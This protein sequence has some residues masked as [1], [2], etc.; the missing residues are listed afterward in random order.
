M[1]GIAGAGGFAAQIADLV[2]REGPSCQPRVQLV[3]V[4]EPDPTTH[5]LRLAE[6]R[7]RGVATTPDIDQLLARP[8]IEAVW[9]PVPIALH[10]PFTER[11]LAAGKA[12][13]VEKPA[14]GTVQ[15]V[16]A[17]IAARDRAQLPVAVGFQ[18]VYD[19]LTLTLKRRLLEGQIG[20]VQHAVLHA[21]WPRSEQYFR[22]NT[23]AGR[24][25]HHGDW[26]LDSPAQ[27]AL[28]HVVN[29]A[30]FLLGPSVSESAWPVRVEAELYR[31]HAIENYDT[32]SLRAHLP[33]G[34]TLLVL[35]THV[36]Q[37]ERGPVLQL[38]GARGCVTWTYRQVDMEAGGATERLARPAADGRNV[39]ERFA[40]LVRGIPDETRLV[41]TLE[42]ARA[43]VML[44][45]AAS[46][47]AAIVPVPRD[48]IV[49]FDR[50]AENWVVITGIDSAIE[51]CAARRQM[52]HESG[53]LP[54]TR[55][56]V[57]RETRNYREFTGP[58][59]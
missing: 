34:A 52:L 3:G 13:M 43:Q 47:A 33:G 28:A 8:D 29:L 26:V 48:Q 45:N 18:H 15:D 57:S 2:R 27:N 16:D 49:R 41:S 12:V 22:R 19:P 53:L 59:G 1:L 6:L 9:L 54:F 4:A 17:M 10:R 55:P 38:A 37:S 32:I 39:L 58:R 21:C 20:Q 40:R 31:A 36:C 56:A 25:Q 5:A 30:L 35:L 50:N 23:W 24:C 11:A 44:V 46:E 7:E 51:Q 14:A 42:T